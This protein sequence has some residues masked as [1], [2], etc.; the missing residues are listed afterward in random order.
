MSKFIVPLH[1]LG[2]RDY[3]ELLCSDFLE[4]F[5]ESSN[6]SSIHR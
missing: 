4:G 2:C 5:I 3:Y 6:S 1:F